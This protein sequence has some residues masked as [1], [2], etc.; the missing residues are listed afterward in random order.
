MDQT[1]IENR[2]KTVFEKIFGKQIRLGPDTGSGDIAGW[3]SLNHVMLTSELEK[4]FGI[5]FGLD[6][7]L[8]MRSFG[9]ICKVVHSKV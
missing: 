1:E 7:M 4:E 3:N 8:G 2:V 9:D 6:E 5:K